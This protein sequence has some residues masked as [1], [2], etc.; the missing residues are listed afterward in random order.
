M[1]Y[2]LEAGKITPEIVIKTLM[3]TWQ[4]IRQRIFPL[5][6]YKFNSIA[7]IYIDAPNDK[8][9]LHKSV[10]IPSFSNQMYLHIIHYCA[11]FLT[12]CTCV[13][14]LRNYHGAWWGCS[15]R[16][17]VWTFRAKSG[18]KTSLH[19]FSTCNEQ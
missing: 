13:E 17:G 10:M 2:V 15:V 6:I 4:R 16:F 11:T 12:S 3:I 8:F 19:L 9:K 18:L 1:K 5:K 14:K 7:F